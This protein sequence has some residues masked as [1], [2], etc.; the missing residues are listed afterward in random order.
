MGC[1]GGV[2]RWSF[3][4]V[5][6]DGPFRTDIRN[7][8][9]SYASLDMITCAQPLQVSSSLSEA[10][11]SSWTAQGMDKIKAMRTKHRNILALD[12]VRPAAGSQGELGCLPAMLP[13]ANHLFPATREAM[14]G[15]DDAHD[16]SREICPDRDN[17]LDRYTLRLQQ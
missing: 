13:R 7:G 10:A 16:R 15:S 17:F 5:V 3:D 14:I 8:R 6:A 11:K 9:A 2:F 1:H 12:L 4:H